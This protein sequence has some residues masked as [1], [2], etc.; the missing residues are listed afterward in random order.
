MKRTIL[1]IEDD[2]ELAE[3]LKYHLERSGDYRVDVALTGQAGLDALRERVPNL[4]ILDINLPEMSGFELCRKIRTEATTSHLP[5]I[6]LTARTSEPDKVLGLTLGA[7]D[8]VTKPF[9]LRELE[10]RIQ[11][12]LRRV[13]G[14]TVSSVY[15][16]G[17]LYVDHKNFLVKVSGEE[18]KLTRKEF[19]LL[20]LLVQSRGRTLTRD[21]LLDRIW[22]LQYYGDSRTLDVHIR[23]LR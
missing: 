9:S 22:G 2:A 6:L 18:V 15:D 3:L 23:N 8:Y 17:V 7:D 1:I 19:A 20:S 12:L 5:I 16:D 14:A 13:E 11:A 10:A 4:L 21:Y